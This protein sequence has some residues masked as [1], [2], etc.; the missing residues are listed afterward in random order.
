MKEIIDKVFACQKLYDINYEDVEMPKCNCCDE[1]RKIIVID[2]FGRKHKVDWQCRINKKKYFYKEC[3]KKISIWKL[4]E[5]D[6][7][8]LTIRTWKSYCYSDTEEVILEYTTQDKEK[9]NY[10]IE[11]FDENNLPKNYYWAYFTDEKEAQKYVDYLNSK[12]N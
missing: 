8:H 6:N 9:R 11:K 1:N 4:K 7:I 3:D 2:M 5:K 10:I 12:E